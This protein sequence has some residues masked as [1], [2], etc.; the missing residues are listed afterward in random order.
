MEKSWY[1]VH[2]I[3]YFELMKDTQDSYLIY[4]NVYLVRA[5]NSELAEKKID[6][7]AKSLQDFN[8]RGTLLVDDEKAK[9]LYKG[10]RKVI[11]LENNLRLGNF[12]ANQSMIELTYSVFE[13]DS[14]SDLCALASGDSVELIYVE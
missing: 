1:C 12:C 11:S 14:W 3:F 5:I 2:A 10:V 13:V 4:E 9:Y 8:E 7:F 6:R